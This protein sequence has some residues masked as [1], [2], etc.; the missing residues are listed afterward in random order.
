MAESVVLGVLAAPGAAQDLAT[1]VEDRLADELHERHPDADWKV[2]LVDEAPDGRTVR[3]LKETAR[4]QMREHRWAMALVLTDLPLLSGRRPVTAHANSQRRVAV[5]SVPALGPLKLKERLVAAVV[6]SVDGILGE[7]VGR[8]GHRRGRRG[9]MAARLQ[10]LGSPLGA[11]HFRD[12]STIRFTSAVIR[13]NLR[14]LAGMV[15]ANNPSLVVVRLSRALAAAG[16]TAAYALTSSSIW[17]LADGASWARLAAISVATLAATM[18]VLIVAHHLWERSERPEDR[19][20]VVLFNLATLAT[21][22]IGVLTLYLALVLIAL[23]CSYAFISPQPFAQQLGHPAG[24]ADHLQLAFYGSAIASLAGALGSL[25][26]S[27]FAVR[28]AMYRY[29]PDARTEDDEE[30]REDEASEVSAGARDK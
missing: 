15:R 2:E 25:T 20:Q 9:R 29:Q 17:T 11:A 5:V 28:E 4:E 19:E 26:E 18:T 12:E 14:L 16:G 10:E 8:G 21:V 6:N 22:L 1:D 23:G 3:E 24:F 30:A 27:D 7:R 13:G